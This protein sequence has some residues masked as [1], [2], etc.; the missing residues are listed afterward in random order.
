MVLTFKEDGFMQV[1]TKERR[2]LGSDDDITEDS[3]AI[4]PSF[5][6]LKVEHVPRKFSAIKSPSLPR[7]S[8]VGSAAAGLGA[9][10]TSGMW[11]VQRQLL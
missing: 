7:S 2:W 1:M 4:F 6:R 3:I 10:N 11:V 5:S 9:A 8:R